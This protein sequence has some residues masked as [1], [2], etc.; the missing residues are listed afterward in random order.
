MNLYLLC[1]ATESD[2]EMFP[3]DVPRPQFQSQFSSES[4]APP[5]AAE[6]RPQTQN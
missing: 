6:K 4:A 3:R 5:R 1:V 2:Q